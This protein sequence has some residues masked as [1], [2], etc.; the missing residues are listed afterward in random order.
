VRA[1][2]ALGRTRASPRIHLDAETL[3]NT[4]MQRSGLSDWGSEDFREPFEILCRALDAEADLT[5]LGRLLA[6]RELTT[7]LESRLRT[8]DTWLRH[9]EIASEEISAP[10]F[11]TG[12]GRS[13]TSILHELLS[14]D[15]D[16]RALLTWEA[17]RPCPPPEPGHR[18][19]DPRIARA[20]REVRLWERIAP[21]YATM[22][23]NGGRA[24]QECIYL[25]AQAF[26]SDLL[27]GYY[28][29]PSYAGWLAK[30]DMQPGY[31]HH[32]R[33][34][35]ALQWRDPP[36]RWVLKAPSHLWTLDALLSV[37]P[38]ARL[39][40]THRDPLVVLPSMASL[41]ATLYW[42]RSDRV[43][44]Q[45]I[46]RQMA[47]SV[48]FMLEKATAQR[49]T[50]LLG[51][52]RVFDVRY[53]DLMQDPIGQI[54]ALYRH[55]AAELSSEAE[56]RMRAYLD[57]KPQGRRGAH[58]YRFEDTGLDLERERERFAPYR[59]RFD[60]PAEL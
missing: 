60:V 29:V 57:A 21:A 35:Q 32:R 44:P 38:D 5:L 16:H 33:V 25:S 7:L 2:N 37:Y 59:K 34:L 26:R 20:E 54:R 27:A 11:V 39:V 40:W 53:A 13:G 43:D 17:L 6:H 8:T 48:G 30:S 47:R 31:A 52:G 24:P 18:D 9:P 19:A 55:F 3:L 22:H 50:D 42:L 4:A 49:D 10:I 36:Q 41:A 45:R 12:S 14:Q 15:P 51:Q 23:E 28:Q 1:L 46:A 56:A 58:R